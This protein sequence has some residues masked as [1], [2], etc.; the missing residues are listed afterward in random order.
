MV[1]HTLVD[2]FVVSCQDDE[3]TLQRQFVSHV[4][5]KALSVRRCEDD[6]VVVALRLQRRNAAVYRLTLHHH[7]CR[8]AIGV[9]IHAAPLVKCVVA[10][11]VQ[12]YL[13][14]SLLLGTCQD[15][16]VNKALQHF[17]QYGND[18]YSHV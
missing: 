3:V 8:P 11:V 17:G 13:G 18:I 10:Q 9:V 4:L 5:V 6:L 14:Q 16:F 7:A 15:G 2:T 12:A 1:T